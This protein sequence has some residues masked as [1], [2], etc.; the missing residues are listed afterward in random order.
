MKIR[1]EVGSE[2]VSY[3]YT[4]SMVGSDGYENVWTLMGHVIDMNNNGCTTK[5]ETR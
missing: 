4:C 5:D 3:G 1:T 2:T